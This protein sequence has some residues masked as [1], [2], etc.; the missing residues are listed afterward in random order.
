MNSVSEP[1][2]LKRVSVWSVTHGA[3]VSYSQVLDVPLTVKIRTGVQQNCNVAH[4][5][6]PEMKKWGVSLITV[7]WTS[8]REFKKQRVQTWLME[9]HLLGLKEDL[10]GTQYV[11]LVS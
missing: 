10:K 1:P 5:L 7:R 3:V 4:K 8:E 11:I 2:L 6:I 9:I